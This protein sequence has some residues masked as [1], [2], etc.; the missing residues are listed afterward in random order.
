MYLSKTLLHTT[1]TYI[2]KLAKVGVH[3][4]YDLIFH[5][6]KDYED[7]SEVIDTF[8]DLDISTKQV[9]QAKV[10][11]INEEMMRSKK[12][13]TKMIVCDIHGSY[14]EVVWWNRRGIATM[15]HAGDMVRIYG[16]VR[17]EYG[18]MSWSSPDIEHARAVRRDIVPVYS[19]INYIPGT[20]I[21]EKMVHVRQYIA[22]IFTLSTSG[23]AYTSI[24]EKISTYSLPEDI[25]IAKG[26]RPLHTSISAL[27]Y[28]QDIPD[29]ERA[30]R[31][32]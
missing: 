29:Y 4:V 3:T 1:D 31:E 13:M 6:P 15:Y 28:P 11:V 24:Y 32:L 25:R 7:K 8:T 23:E 2:K 16:T 18:K 22:D 19:D 12:L 20:W 14:A 9:M 27:H 21:R 30:R 26:F 5:F 17:Y 10:T